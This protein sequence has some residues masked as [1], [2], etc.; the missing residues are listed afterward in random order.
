MPVAQEEAPAPEFGSGAGAFPRP[1]PS[2][3][4]SSCTSP[5]AGSQ[6]S[7]ARRSDGNATATVTVAPTQTRPPIVTAL[8]A[9]VSSARKPTAALPS[10]G[11]T[12]AWAIH[13]PLTRPRSSSGVPC[14]SRAERS[15][16]EIRSPKP[17]RARSSSASGSQEP[18]TEAA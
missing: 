12:V 10:A 5:S 4:V 18:Q 13:N 3:R 16:S 6:P 9:L 14:W 15:V 7:R 17:A 8:P 2:A 11:D 1:P